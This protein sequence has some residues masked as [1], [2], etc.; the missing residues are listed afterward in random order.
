MKMAKF[1]CSLCTALAASLFFA[2]NLYASPATYGLA[3][4]APYNG[5][6]NMV[7]SRRP[8]PDWRNMIGGPLVIPEG[9]KLIALTFD[10]GPSGHTPRLLDELQMRGAVATFFTSGNMIAARQDVAARIVEEGHE[11][12][13]HAYS[14]PYLTSLSTDGIRRELTNS[15][16]A[17]YNATGT[18]PAV[19]RPPYGDQ[20]AAVR[21][22]AAEFDMPLIL[23]SI[24]TIDWRDRNVQTILSRIVDSQGNPRVQDG[25]IILMHDTHATTVDATIEIVDILQEQGFFFVTVSQLFEARDIQLVPGGIHRSAR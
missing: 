6:W 1:L 21:S 17:I 19:F 9:A 18:K 7:D 24:D 16:N 2:A 5:G 8:N 22:V 12:A 25:D 14:H 13:C 15:R 10:D 3:A 4:S 23:W 20:N 11:I